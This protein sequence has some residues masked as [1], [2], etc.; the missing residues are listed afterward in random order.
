MSGSDFLKDLKII[1]CWRHIFKKGKIMQYYICNITFYPAKV[2]LL[3]NGK[4]VFSEG[5]EKENIII[6]ILDRLN[7]DYSSVRNDFFT[8]HIELFYFN[9]EESCQKALSRL[10]PFFSEEDLN[11]LN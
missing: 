6:P 3:K 9:D 4:I 5:R 8:H 7:C 11:L 2:Y 10:N 1:S